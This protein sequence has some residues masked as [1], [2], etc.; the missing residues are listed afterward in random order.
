MI[1]SSCRQF[2]ARRSPIAWKLPGN[3]TRPDWIDGQK[4]LRPVPHDSTRFSSS[5]I[6]LRTQKQKLDQV[7]LKNDFLANSNRKTAPIRRKSSADW[8]FLE[9]IDLKRF[10]IS[11]NRSR[12]KLRC[13]SLVSNSRIDSELAS[14]RWN[15]E[16]NEF[17]SRSEKFFV[18]FFTSIRSIELEQVDIFELNSSWTFFKL[19]LSRSVNI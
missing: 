11:T 9:L 4:L 5:T 17:S 10:R 7:K 15:D 2:S 8:K 19:I 12:R 18:F 1:W 6:V 14:C 3:S 16:K 13:A